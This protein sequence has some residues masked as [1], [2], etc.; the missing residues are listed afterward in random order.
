[1]RDVAVQTGECALEA[2]ERGSCHTEHWIV[3][4]GRHPRNLT[5]GSVRASQERGQKAPLFSYAFWTDADDPG[6]QR[7]WMRI[8][9]NYEEKSCLRK[10]R[11]R[12]WADF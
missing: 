7:E 11:T 3:V 5:L 6:G 4:E 12:D 8:N 10:S 9:A 2:N 1:M